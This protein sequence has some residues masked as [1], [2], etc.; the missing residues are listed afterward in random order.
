MTWRIPLFELEYDH[1]E[2]ASVLEVLR[3]RW[4]TMGEQTV[5]FESAFTE[6]LGSGRV[7][8][9]ANCTASLHMAVRSAGVGA[10]DE[11]IV[12]A[13]TFVA[14]A[15]AVLYEGATPVFADVIGEDDLTLDPADVASKITE[16]TRA[17][18]VVHYAGYP[19]RMRE[20]LEIASA[21]GL[22]VIEDC[23][24]APGASYAGHA[25]GTLGDFGC[26]S[27]FSNKNLSTGEGGAIWCRDDAAAERLRLM[28]SHG[29][30]AQT[31]DRHKG[32]AWG[33]DVVALGYNYRL[34]E[35]EAALARVQLAKLRENNARRASRV[36]RYRELLAG[37]PGIT[38]PFSATME[39]A[40]HLMVVLLPP[41]AVRED[42]QSAL[43]DEGIQTSVHYRP[44][45]TFSAE[46]L[47]GGRAER[48][49]RV[50]AIAGRLLT[51]PLWPGMTDEQVEAVVEALR[52]ALSGS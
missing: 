50:D 11:V 24:H 28:R 8:A 43:K 14:T 17:I 5:A 30:T 21:N 6:F 4:L 31:L 49:G 48:L 15:N 3:S 33:Y 40:H 27:F 2:E 9:T 45:H 36:A 19:C 1:Q 41:C 35:I 26:F 20:I 25:L 44:L 46:G 7:L 18:I 29:M 32:H 22:A 10:G 13:L 34:T 47:A 23:A 38:V 52:R 39:S 12:P 42:V 16:R 51:L 37:V